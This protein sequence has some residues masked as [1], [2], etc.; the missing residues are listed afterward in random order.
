MISIRFC[1]INIFWLIL[2]M[3]SFDISNIDSRDRN[4]TY[5]AC[6]KLNVNFEIEMKDEFNNSY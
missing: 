3:M 6:V 2:T 5:S 1:L 4:A